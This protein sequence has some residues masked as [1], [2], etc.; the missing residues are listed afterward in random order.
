[1]LKIG[2]SSAGVDSTQYSSILDRYG[3]STVEYCAGRGAV[4]SINAQSNCRQSQ[5]TYSIHS[6]YYISMTNPDKIENNCQMIEKYCRVANNMNA[7]RLIIHAGN[8]KQDNRRYAKSIATECFKRGVAIA[9]EYNVTLCPETVGKYSVYGNILEVIELCEQIEELIPCIDI[10]HIN[11]TSNGTFAKFTT[12]VWIQ[13]LNLIANRIGTERMK[14][15]HWHVSKI[16][17]ANNNEIKHLNFRDEGEPDF[18]YLIQAL[19]ELDCNGRIICESATDNVV[20]AIT[21][22]QYYNQLI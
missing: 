15:I 20:D 5:Y 12:D 17:Y 9:S 19:A 1:M 13:Y 7:D 3:L 4:P 18:R 21:M 14:S 11:C 10:G 8:L 16:A 2:F 22:Q 6:P